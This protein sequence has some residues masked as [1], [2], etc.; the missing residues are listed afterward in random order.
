MVLR[1][2]KLYIKKMLRMGYTE[3]MAWLI[4]WAKKPPV[5]NIFL[6]REKKI[7]NLFAKNIGIIKEM[8]QVVFHQALVGNIWA[9]TSPKKQITGREDGYLKSKLKVLA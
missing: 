8:Q 4:R 5:Q 7:F 1:V 3:G 9:G 2:R 6:N